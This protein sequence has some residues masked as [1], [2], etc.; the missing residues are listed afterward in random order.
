LDKIRRLVQD[1]VPTAVIWSKPK[2]EV[3]FKYGGCLFFENGNSYISA[4]D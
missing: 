3:E 4:A 2:P 1:D